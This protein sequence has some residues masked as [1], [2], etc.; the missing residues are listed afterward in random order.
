MKRAFNL[1]IVFCL[2]VAAFL[3]FGTSI[4]T[5]IYYDYG[6]D[7]D[8]PHYGRENILLLLLLCAGVVFVLMVLKTNGV[9]KREKGPLMF[10]LAFCTAYCLMLILAIRP[11]PV[12]DSKTLDDIINSFMSGDYSSLTSKEGYLYIWPFQLGYVAFGQLMCTVFGI[13]NY[14]AWDLIQLLSILITVYLL[15]QMTWE[16]FGDREICSIMAVLSAGMLFF[17]NYVTYIYGDIL[18]MAPQTIAL[19][20]EI[21]YMKKK[22]IGYGIGAGVAIAFAIM[23]KTNCEIALIALVVILVMNLISSSGGKNSLLKAVL[24]LLI[25]FGLTFGIK[26]VVNSYYCSV[27]GL[28]A[29]PTGSPAVSHIAMGMQESELEDGWYNGYNYHVFAENGY[30]TEATKAAAIEN[31]KETLSVFADRPLHAGR[32]FVRKFLTQWAD[33]VCISTHNLDLVNRHHDNPT[34]LAGFLVSGFGSTI[35]QWVMNVYM[36]I[37]YLGVVIYLISVLKKKSVSE[38]EMLVLILIFGGIVFHE[39][40][41]GSSRYAMRYYVYWIPFAAFGLKKLLDYIGE[42]F[43]K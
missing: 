29:I 15:Y 18:S 16:F 20:L 22:D 38:P 8:W 17:Y 10:E 19:F 35:M 3:V 11:L 9:F 41:E 23:L 34:W 40:W 30:D 5:T 39:F 28:D 24:I 7:N 21:L 31:I 25:M 37:C 33:S 14:I 36:T 42:K 1:I 27:T 32:F 4:L 12:N 43:E 13:G 6:C 2:L 26:N